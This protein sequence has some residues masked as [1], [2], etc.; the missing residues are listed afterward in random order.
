MPEG[1]SVQTRSQA[2]KANAAA[3][4]NAATSPGV[5]SDPADTSPPLGDGVGGDASVGDVKSEVKPGDA[6]T[7]ASTGL[8]GSCPPEDL[9]ARE[10]AALFAACQ[11]LRL[12]LKSIAGDVENSVTA[13]HSSDLE[14]S[15]ENRIM[16]VSYIKSIRRVSAELKTQHERVLQV[17]TD[18]AHASLVNTHCSNVESTFDEGDHAEAAAE[19]MLGCLNSQ[20]SVSGTGDSAVSS[21]NPEL[22]VRLPAHDLPKFSGNCVDWPVFWNQFRIAVHDRSALPA[23]HKFVYLKQCLSGEALDLVKSLLIAESSYGT[24]LTL[25]RQRFED[26]RLILRDYIDALI[27]VPPAQANNPASLRRLVSVFQ[28]KYTGLLNAG[29][30]TGYLFLTHMLNRKLDH[31]TKRAWEFARLSTAK[32]DE[33]KRTAIPPSGS[34]GPGS[35]GGGGLHGSGSSEHVLTAHPRPLRHKKRGTRSF[36]C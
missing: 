14:A 26:T 9:A 18:P 13:Y 23:I 32:L 15:H 27:N 7:T 28:D 33:W 5:N 4:S 8:G 35:F 17:V 20:I 22:S 36:P 6:F 10:R 24:A 34:G 3:D 21:N 19:E 29:V 31:E 2:A 16:V 11:R 30:K 1:D 12:K 25:L